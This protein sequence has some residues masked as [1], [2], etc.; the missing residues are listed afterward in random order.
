MWDVILLIPDHCLPIFNLR[1]SKLHAYSMLQFI[2]FVPTTVNISIIRNR[3]SQ[4]TT[5]AVSCK[6]MK[7]SCCFLSLHKAAVHRG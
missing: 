5:L 4:F 2:P 3:M 1:K 6:Y 7:I